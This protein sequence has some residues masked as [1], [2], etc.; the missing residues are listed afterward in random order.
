MAHPAPRAP[1]GAPTR[2]PQDP[3]LPIDPREGAA[4][5]G[6][7][8][9]HEAVRLVRDPLARTIW[10]VGTPAVA[11]SLLMTV[12]ASVD[13]FWV[14]TRVGPTGL[15]AVS[16]ALFWVWLTVSIAEMV[17]VGLTAVAARRHGERRHDEAALVVGDALLFAIALGAFVALVGTLALD[18]LCE[19][20]RTPPA[21]TALGERYL[22]TY[23][24][25]APL[26]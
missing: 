1:T 17:S 21:V 15:A 22:F 24:L 8:S 12:F 18:A 11:S 25:G 26:I 9:E 10:R 19:I 7:S 23:L 2:P 6:V 20:M 4:S 13:A 14:G 16:T 3:E 5:V